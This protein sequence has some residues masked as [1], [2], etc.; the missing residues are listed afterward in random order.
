MFLDTSVPLRLRLSFTPQLFVLR[1]ETELRSV[2][3]QGCILIRPT[4]KSDA[5]TFRNV[6][7]NV[8]RRDRSA[9][10]SIQQ[11]SKLPLLWNLKAYFRKSQ[12]TNICFWICCITR[13]RRERVW[14]NDVG[15]VWVKKKGVFHDGTESKKKKKD[16]FKKTIVCI[17][18]RT[19]SY[20]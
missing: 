16:L 12:L 15:L 9:S 18:I 19:M 2:F 8:N 7:E 3:N 1:F 14:R 5:T 10:D 17:L 6:P 13:W 11:S 4:N 20:S